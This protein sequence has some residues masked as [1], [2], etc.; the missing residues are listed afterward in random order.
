MPEPTPSFISR[1]LRGSLGWAAAISTVHF[2][3]GIALIVVLNMPP[4]TGFAAQSYAMEFVLA[5][6]IGLVLSPLLL[7]P[8]GGLLHPLALA[9]A[10]IGL[11]RWVAVD[12][13]K[14]QMWIGP[15]IGALVVWTIGKAIWTRKPAVVIG[16][17]VLVPVVGL[18]VPVAIDAN[19]ADLTPRPGAATAPKGAPDVLFI[20]MDTVRAQS[21]SSYGYTRK[22]TPNF[23]EMASEGV[24]FADANSPAT[25]SLP[26]HASL[27]T[28]TFP[29]WNDAN[30]ETRY[31]DDKL[32]TLAETLLDAGWQTRCFSAN[33]Y[34]SDSF[35]LTRGFQANDKA[36]MS[37][38]SGRNFS[39]IYRLLDATPFGGVDDKGGATVIGNIRHW[40]AG[41]PADGPPQFV[42]V[43]FLEAHFPFQQLPTEFLT[44][45]QDRPISELREANQI[46]FGVQFGRQLS[47]QEF[48]QIHQP[49]VDM[50]DGGV[51][52]TDY[53]VGQTLDIWRKAG[54][55]DNTIVVVLGDHGESMGE[56]G[57]FG[58]VTPVSNEI[59]RVPFAIRYPAKI[60]AGSRVEQPVS[61]VG[62]MATILDLADVHA[63]GVSQ[64]GT[65]MPGLQGEEVGKP[66]LV[67]RFEEHMMAS[68]FAPGTANGHGPLVNPHGRFR[69]Y[70]SGS[71]KLVEH[72]TDG[73]VVFDLS[74]D[75]GETTNILERD[76]Y[77]AD[78][79]VAE[80]DDWQRKLGLP[81][82]DAPI[83]AVK[84][85]PEDLSNEEIEA[86]RA[87]G[88]ME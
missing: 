66:I 30:G 41:R 55:L 43:N 59:T 27:F 84:K 73:N 85:M 1:A 17:G 69:T 18:L 57:A 65:L 7:V 24:L 37:G 11:E 54:Y 71:Y 81:D 68:R 34:I 14:L 67:E 4:L 19:R 32:P 51:R 56:H 35:G 42:F 64:V 61:T 8:K 21:S 52:Y 31:L 25:W 33:P 76:P 40:M 16:L 20:V 75:P 80:L 60:R 82:L 45:Y 86:L 50:Y 10:W 13:S 77:A 2:V 63:P 47:P 39:F 83:D 22:T 44:S 29:S 48:E 74:K 5:F 70:R 87:L 23:D 53:L 12:P 38:T 28:G 72:S 49:L 46:A 26:A 62:T 3:T 36:W 88:Y 79:L 15:T 78:S 9:A 58:H 6:V